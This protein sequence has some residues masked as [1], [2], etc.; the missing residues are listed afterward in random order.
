M[1]MSSHPP[2]CGAYGFDAPYAPLLM[3]LGGACLLVLSVT[4]LWLGEGRPAL[5]SGVGLLVGAVWLFLQLRGI[6]KD[7]PAKGDWVV[8]KGGD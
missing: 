2:R 8:G 3:A 7:Q 4:R 6:A 1:A 5:V